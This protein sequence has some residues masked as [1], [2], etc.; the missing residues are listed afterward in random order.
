MHPDLTHD[1]P[2]GEHWDYNDGE[3]GQWRIYPDGGVEPK[4][5]EQQP[6]QPDPPKPDPKK[7]KPHCADGTTDCKPK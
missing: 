6:T 3:G 4:K 1:Q 7:D 2:V 5:P